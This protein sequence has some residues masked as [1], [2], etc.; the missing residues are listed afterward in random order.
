MR[1]GRKF[2]TIYFLFFGALS[3]LAVIPAV[4]LMVL[5][6]TS[7]ALPLFGAPGFLVIA[8][9]TI[10][11]YSSALV[12]LWRALAVPGRGVWP[13]AIALAAGVPIA[14]AIAI[15]PGS[16]SQNAARLFGLRISK[17]DFSRPPVAAKPKS[18]ELIGDLNSGLFAS[19]QAV[20][21]SYAPCNEVCRRL[22]LIAKPTGCE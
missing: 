11:L 16:L 8:S 5:L 6:L 12:P 21:D 9:P 1:R 4:P 14:A 19:G 2:L 17:D 20:G 18:I 15:A 22:L 10:L 13:I 7:M 3:I